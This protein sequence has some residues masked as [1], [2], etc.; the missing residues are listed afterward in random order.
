MANPRW[1][2]KYL[3]MK[4]EV[5]Q[6]YN[7]LDAWLNYCRFHMIKFDEAD[8][9]KSVAYKEWQEKRKRREQWRSR[10]QANRGQ[11]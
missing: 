9:Y 10:D 3:T 2:N 5:K 7:D 1:L 4:S 11:R 8:L 6:I